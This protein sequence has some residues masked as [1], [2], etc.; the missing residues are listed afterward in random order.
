[1]LGKEKASNGEVLSMLEMFN[2]CHMFGTSLQGIKRLRFIDLF[3][4]WNFKFLNKVKSLWKDTLCVITPTPVTED[5]LKNLRLGT[6][7]MTGWALLAPAKNPAVWISARLSLSLINVRNQ[8]ERSQ[9][10]TLFNVLRS[11]CGFVISNWYYSLVDMPNKSLIGNICNFELS[12]SLINVRNL[13]ERSQNLTLFD[14]LRSSCG[15]VI[16]KW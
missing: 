7:P 2:S 3:I 9:N 6:V 14:A 8:Y 12:L 13:Y 10:L 5:R 4:F 16:S 1:M 15:F 11:S